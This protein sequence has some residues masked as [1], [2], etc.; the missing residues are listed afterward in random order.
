MSDNP[1]N[2][3]QGG[4]NPPP[5]PPPGDWSQAPGQPPS[6]QWGG[7]DQ[8]GNQGG[9][10]QPQPQYGQQQPQ[11]G[12]GMAIAAL[13]LGILGFIGGF[14]V[15][16]AL[17]GVVAIILGFIARWKV[18]RG[19]A[20]GGGMALAGII[21]GILGVLIAVAFVAL[22]AALFNAAED[23]FDSFADCVEQAG[24]DQAALDACGQDFTEDLFGE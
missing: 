20:T 17:L 4:Q 9:G 18:K 8:W 14:F 24:N 5:G 2:P 7:Q 12:N 6:Q 15:V 13:V 11:G 16:G 22:G 3:G 10:Y 23:N 1:Q 19:E 21:L